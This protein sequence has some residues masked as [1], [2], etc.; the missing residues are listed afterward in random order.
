MSREPYFCI[1]GR[2]QAY[3]CNPRAD[4][5]T[6]HF[7]SDFQAKWCQILVDFA[8]IWANF[9]KFD[10]Y[11]AEKQQK[12]KI[13]KINFAIIQVSYISNSDTKM[14]FS[15]P[16]VVCVCFFDFPTFSENKAN[17]GEKQ[18]FLTKYPRVHTSA[19]RIV[20]G[21]VLHLL[22]YPFYTPIL[23][24]SKITPRIKIDHGAP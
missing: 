8:Q 6:F 16:T 9:I 11:L 10:T 13:I 17:I 20:S 4:F 3:L 12:M 19:L 14:K 2:T 23:Y 21:I 15:A 7:L 1:R 22:V 18:I 24:M 5:L